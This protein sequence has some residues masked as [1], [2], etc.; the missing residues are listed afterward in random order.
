MTWPRSPSEQ[1]PSLRHLHPQEMEQVLDNLEAAWQD[2]PGLQVLWLRLQMEW[3]ETLRQMLQAS[4]ASIGHLPSLQGRLAAL[5][6]VLQL[7]R[8]LLE[9]ARALPEGSFDSAR[10]TTE[11]SA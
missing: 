6:W 1:P 3:R 9:E 2:H 11:R 8:T 10:E 4:P 7:P 5:E